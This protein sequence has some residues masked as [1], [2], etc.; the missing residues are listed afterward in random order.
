LWIVRH[1]S[2]KASTDSG[3]TPAFWDNYV[4]PKVDGTFR[5]LYNFLS[6]PYPRGPNP[7]VQRIENNL[8]RLRT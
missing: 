6:D 4:R 3:N 5:G 1:S 2:R 7:Y 8:A